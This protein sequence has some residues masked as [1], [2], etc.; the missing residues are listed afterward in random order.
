[1]TDKQSAMV[2]KLKGYIE[3]HPEF[4]E[5]IP[6]LCKKVAQLQKKQAQIR[7]VQHLTAC[8]KKANLTPAQNRALQEKVA[9]DYFATQRVT[10]PKN[11]AADAP[12]VDIL[13]HLIR[14]ITGAKNQ[15]AIVQE[16]TTQPDKRKHYVDTYR[17]SPEL[18]AK[19]QDW[20]KTTGTPGDLTDW[21]KFHGIKAQ[22]ELLKKKNPDLAPYF[23]AHMQ[24]ML[25]YT[26][27]PGSTAPNPEEY[28]AQWHQYAPAREQELKD[29]Y[30]KNLAGWYQ[31]DLANENV[32]PDLVHKQYQQFMTPTPD[33][34]DITKSIAERDTAWNNRYNAKMYKKYRSMTP[35]E[36]AQ[37]GD[38]SQMPWYRNL[39]EKFTRWLGIP[40]TPP[41]ANG[42]KAPRQGIKPHQMTPEDLNRSEGV[43]RG[44]ERAQKKHDDTLT[45]SWAPP[46]AQQADVPI[47]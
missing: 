20:L 41:A 5:Q 36:L 39:P 24:K 15:D 18:A 8:V 47:F 43:R 31:E 13:R 32:G 16:F 44:V 46:G 3:Q 21:H 22:Y 17:R 12:D 34:F 4:K 28:W 11:P 37:H 25:K 1:M 30:N 26:P 33:N 45:P 19:M 9:Y 7:R 14:N 42:G 23:K 6:G 2:K 29:I 27:T 38:Y 40:M 10:P 35:E